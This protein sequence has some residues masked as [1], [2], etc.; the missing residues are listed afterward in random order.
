MM[1]IK[2]KDMAKIV[3]CTVLD[4]RFTVRDVKNACDQAKEY[5]FA[6]VCVNP[7]YVPL[8]A[9]LLEESSVK[10]CTVVGYPLGSNTSETKAF[11]TKS[12]IRNGAQ[13]I[14]M[15]VNVAAIKEHNWMKVKEDV[16]AV[17]DAT[18]IAGVTRDIITKAVLETEYL[19]E[20]E[21]E[22]VC[23]IIKR[24]KVDFIAVS[25][26]FDQN[27]IIDDVGFIRKLVGRTIGVKATGGID[28]FETALDMLDAGANRIGTKSGISIVI[29]EE[30]EIDQSF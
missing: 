10:V 19:T 16:K 29:G 18:K 27:A 6:A 21:L 5:N 12:V 25:S 22:T 4:P 20:E 7:C 26:G 28:D 30:D 2:P 23:L 17:I 14:D 15:V 9:K 13:E 8:T 24:L 3:D 11:E 1:A